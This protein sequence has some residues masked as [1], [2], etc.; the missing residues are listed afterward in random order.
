VLRIEPHREGFT[1]RFKEAPIFHHSPSSPCVHVAEAPPI[2]WVDPGRGEGRWIRR[3]FRETAPLRECRIIEETS[4][5]VVLDFEGRLGLDIVVEDDHLSLSFRSD[6][7]PEGLRMDFDRAAGDAIFGGGADSRSLVD[8]AHSRLEAWGSDASFS[9]IDRILHRPVRGR[10]WPLM[11]FVTESNRWFRL[12][13]AGWMAADFRAK[14]R[15]SFEFSRFPDAMLVGVEQDMAAAVSSLGRRSGLALGPPVW[16]RGGPIVS[17]SAKAGALPALV[18]R[19][20]KAGID[21]AGIRLADLDILDRTAAGDQRAAILRS[22]GLRALAVAR[23]GR[24]IADS[25]DAIADG[26]GPI[27]ETEPLASLRLSGLRVE[28]ADFLSVSTLPLEDSRPDFR[29]S[30]RL[31]LFSRAI[32]EAARQRLASMGGDFAAEGFL[33]SSAKGWGMD[34][35]MHACSL[36][37]VVDEAAAIPRR[38]SAYLAHGFS[39]GG[40]AW[41]D[42]SCA[43]P[44]KGAKSRPGRTAVLAR[45]R[46]IELAA[47]GPVLEFG[48]PGDGAMDEEELRLLAR[49]SSIFSALGPYHESVADEYRR[50]LLPPIR[51]SLIHYCQGVEARRGANHYLYGR[52]LLVAVSGGSGEFVSL[53][54][55]EDDWIHIW[56][57][58]HFRGGPV[59]IE[60]AT[61]RPAVFYRGASPFAALFDAVRRE[62]RRK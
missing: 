59:S 43:F 4:G 31:S 57:S 60:A 36:P 47:F 8:V 2:Q 21:A 44:G 3:C 19:L 56:S 42:A 6:R 45:R 7:R 13:G 18:A 15:I 54:L 55:P 33:L 16:T 35:E 28:P 49:M 24:G 32:R 14:G 62:T 48:V 9:G 50:T 37:A 25:V 10:D 52:D 20:K 34:E 12:E 22:E 30:L 17:T 53:D 23:P 26:T 40:W 29:V 1:L 27:P 39:G 11:S 58:R 41:L 61:G 38:M 5:R 51:H 46:A